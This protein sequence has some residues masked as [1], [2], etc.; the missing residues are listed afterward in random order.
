M[1][2]Q[3]IPLELETV[4]K[5]YLEL[6]QFVTAKT[7]REL[8]LEELLR[9]AHAIAKRCGADTAWERFAESIQ[10][11]GISDVTARTYR[12]L[13]SDWRNEPERGHL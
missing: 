8:E 9:S 1:N 5:L 4:N 13:P 7:A 10:Q 11:A 12:V 6:S 2:A 3:Q